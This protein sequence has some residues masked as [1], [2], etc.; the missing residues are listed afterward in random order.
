MKTTM[1]LYYEPSEEELK[2]AKIMDASIMNPFIHGDFSIARGLCGYAPT[3]SWGRMNLIF[4]L[5]TAHWFGQAL[6]GAMERMIE[7]KIG[8]FLYPAANKQKKWVRF[9][10]K[11]IYE[12]LMSCLELGLPV[13]IETALR[14]LSDYCFFEEQLPVP[15]DSNEWTGGVSGT[16]I[17]RQW[18]IAISDD[19]R[20]K[21]YNYFE[22]YF[23]HI[24][25]GDIKRWLVLHS[26]SVMG[27]PSW[28][29]EDENS[30]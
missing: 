1:P 19:E 13:T 24:N 28:F 11:W 6:G 12:A 29:D 7:K 27:T 3:A 8:G 22:E 20:E 30:S 25:Q 15:I 9:D 18:W 10:R 4:V 17:I 2:Q 26:V 14:L 21:H 16:E 5:T 23:S